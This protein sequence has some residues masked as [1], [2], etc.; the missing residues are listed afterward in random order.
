MIDTDDIK[1]AFATLSGL[2]NWLLQLDILL[3][4]LISVASLLYIVT[5]YVKLFTDKDKKD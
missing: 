2:G 4:V 1:V 5:K 3:Q